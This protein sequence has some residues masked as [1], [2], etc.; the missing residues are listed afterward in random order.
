MLNLTRIGVAGHIPN[1]LGRLH[2]LR[3]LDLYGNGLSDAI[4]STIGNLTR[5]EFLRLSNNILSDQIPFHPT[6]SGSIT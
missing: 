5:L 4:P 1:E 6:S 2:R 3:F